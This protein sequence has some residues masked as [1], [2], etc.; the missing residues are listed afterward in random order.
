MCLFG[1]ED[2]GGG[3]DGAGQAAPPYLVAA[4]YMDEPDAAQRVLER[5]HGGNA[6]HSRLR[7]L[8]DFAVSFIRAALPFKSR[9]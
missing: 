5:A 8:C 6:G 9:R 3:H 4:G 7:Q 1:V 2:D